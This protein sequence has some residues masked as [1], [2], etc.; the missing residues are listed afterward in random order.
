[1]TTTAELL[2][3]CRIFAEFPPA[4]LAELAAMASVEEVPAGRR[5]TT[6]GHAPDELVVV[7]AGRFRVESAGDEVAQLGVGDA[8]GEISL[9]DDGVASADAVALRPSL[10]VELPIASIREL[11]LQQ[12]ESLLGLAAIL[13]ER[14]RDRNRQPGP[15]SPRVVAVRG[16]PETGALIDALLAANPQARVADSDRRIWE[17]EPDHLVLVDGERTDTLSDVELIVRGAGRPVPEQRSPRRLDLHLPGRPAQPLSPGASLS[18]AVDPS[19]PASVER[20]TRL[21]VGGAEAL[22]LGGGGWRTSATLG[23]LE[24]LDTA[25]FSY[26]LIVGVSA[27]SPTAVLV[28]HEEPFDEIMARAQRF[29]A[30]I[31]LGRDLWPSSSSITTGR[32]LTGAARRACG[33]LRLEDLARPVLVGVSSVTTGRVLGVREGPAWR[34]VRASASLPAVFPPMPIGDEL[35]VDGGVIDN[36]PVDLVNQTLPDPVVTAVSVGRPGD[37]DVGTFDEDGV[38]SRTRWPTTPSQVASLITACAR[39]RADVA[40]CDHLI[41][42]DIGDA[43]LFDASQFEEALERGRRAGRAHVEHRRRA[44]GA[45]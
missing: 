41:E 9:I 27:M 14:L 33:D 29:A 6:A 8:I 20:L 16:G 26:D 42:P 25:G 37:L 24:E 5:V 11:L 15:G 4:L 23:V 40:P 2:A 31:R 38:V 13:A 1:M 7:A 18:I 28:G 35:C 12:S 34:A 22:V 45:E 32:S 19:D 44:T 43:S 39:S 30:D 3:R 17:L 10:V 36:L 21:A